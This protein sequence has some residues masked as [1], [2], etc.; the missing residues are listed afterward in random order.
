M[1]KLIVLLAGLFLANTALAEPVGSPIP[2]GIAVGQTTNVALFGEEQV[3][4][5]KV[6]EKL[7]NEKGGV[8]GTPIRLAFQDTA[9][10][11][12]GAINAFQNLITRDKVVAIIG[13]PCPSRPSPPTPSPTRPRSPSSAR[14]TRP[15]ASPRSASTSP[16]SPR[17]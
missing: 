9:G 13:R 15:R 14:P 5:A 4:G 3:N 16:A 11:E 1:R 8:G 17:P 6:A 2:V 12:A 7:L 10:D